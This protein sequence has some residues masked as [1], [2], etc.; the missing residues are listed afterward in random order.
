M[1]FQPNDDLQRAKAELTIL[2][3]W[4]FAALP[5]A[6]EGRD[7]KYFSPFRD[8]RTPSFSISQQGRVWCDFG[9][10]GQTKG[11]VWEFAEKVWPNAS[12]GEIA[13]KLIEASG[14]VPTPRASPVAAGD[15]AATP[16]DPALKRAA[17]DLARKRQLREA[18]ERPY[19]ERDKRLERPEL[20]PATPWP[21]VVRDRF[22]EGINFLRQNPKKVHDLARDRGWPDEWAWEL[23]E[24]ELVSFP[25]ERR[26]D[27]QEK[28][29]RRQKAFRVDAPVIKGSAAALDAIGY[30]QRF[31]I[32]ARGNEPAQKK[33]M[34]IPSVPKFTPQSDFER[35]IEAF[36]KE[37]GS[38]RPSPAPLTPPLPFVLG[39]LNAPRVIVL[40]EGQWDAI[41]FFGACGYFQDSTPPAGIAV[42]GIR[43]SQ[44]IDPFLAHWWPWLAHVAPLC[45]VIADNDPAGSAWR[46]A[47]PAERGKIQMPSFAERLKAAGCRDVLIS[48]LNRGPWG[49]DFNDYFKARVAA[50]A[51]PGPEPMQ[52]WMRKVGVLSSSGRFA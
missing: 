21:G 35:A 11:G 31:F 28:F 25:F 7:G 44:G 47:P 15:Q 2:R 26:F 1:T 4:E 45:W 50:G 18:D 10:T 37:H 9:G 43:G 33:W 6:R 22:A 42:F 13:A 29:A 40:L 49:K 39:D 3:L 23:L 19:L 32:P 46:E 5:A 34:F 52:A 41:T 20:K 48:W 12:P 8:E 14:I 24:L 27:G 30:H 16:V 17:A 36:G 51:M 38:V